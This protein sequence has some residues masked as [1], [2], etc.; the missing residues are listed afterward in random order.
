MLST[1]PRQNNTRFNDVYLKRFKR[2]LQKKNRS[3]KYGTKYF[4]YL[5]VHLRKIKTLKSEVVPNIHR[6]T[7]KTKYISYLYLCFKASKSLHLFCSC[8][9]E[10]ILASCFRPVGHVKSRWR[11]KYLGLHRRSTSTAVVFQSS[12]TDSPPVN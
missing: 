5:L 9:T 8:Y 4:V 2:C 3:I 1:V 10:T 12:S 11:L 6:P 7:K